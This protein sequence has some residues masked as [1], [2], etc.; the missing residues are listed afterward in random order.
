[1]KTPI[2][3]FTLLTI[4]FAGQ[5]Q[6]PV[7]GLKGGL[8]I[9]SIDNSTNAIFSNRLGFNG[10]LYMNIPVN[11]AVSVQP[12]VVYSTQGAKYN[13][14]GA[15]EHNLMLTYVNI[16]VMIQANVGRGVYAEAGPQIGLL[17]SVKDQVDKVETGFFTSEDFKK[18]DVGL[19]LGLGYRGAGGFGVNVRYN[20]GLTNINN[21]GSNQLRNNNLQVG[22]TVGFGR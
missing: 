2:L 1:M 13:L 9:S 5:A 18:T 22:L 20:L 3:L 7:I 19:G 10:G 6:N 4:A 14:N 15:E 21:Y 12:E 16:P 11:Q 8:N 17:A